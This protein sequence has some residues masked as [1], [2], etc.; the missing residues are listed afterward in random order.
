MKIM[1]GYFILLW[2]ASIGGLVNG[3]ARHRLSDAGDPRGRGAQSHIIS[4]SKIIITQIHLIS[5]RCVSQV[6]FP[7]DPYDCQLMYM[8]KVL[9]SVQ[10]TPPKY[11][12]L[13]SPTGTGKT[14]CLLCSTLSWQRMQKIAN[15]AAQVNAQ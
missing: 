4:T 13:E 3:G 6:S 14:L 5:L 7:F 1:D 2:E 12:L 11:A 10:S 15:A 9:M 8:E